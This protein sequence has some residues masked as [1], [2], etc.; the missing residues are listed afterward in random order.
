[1]LI[2][3]SRKVWENCLFMAPRKK[4]A[5]T[6]LCHRLNVLADLRFCWFTTS[7]CQRSYRKP[8]WKPQAESEKP[9]RFWSR[10]RTHTCLFNHAG[11][12]ENKQ[13]IAFLFSI[14][15]VRSRWFSAKHPAIWSSSQ[16]Q[17]KS[18]YLLPAGPPNRG[19]TCWLKCEGT[20]LQNAWFPRHK[21]WVKGK[22]NSWR[23][24]ERRL[25]DSTPAA[26]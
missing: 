24:K 17:T 6:K 20:P 16:Q 23:A 4:S 22:L 7:K 11:N 21:W 15:A 25:S 9:Q 5:T 19:L 1:M 2:R 3:W 26:G 13:V 8:R 12:R 14:I 18:P 10:S